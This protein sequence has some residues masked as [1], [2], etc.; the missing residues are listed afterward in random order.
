MDHFLLLKKY[1]IKYL[2]KYDST[3]KNL[4]RVLRN[5]IRRINNASKDKKF[6]LFKLIFK[7]I[8]ELE[9]KQILNDERYTDKKI[10][11]FSSQ[12]KSKRFI[13]NYLMQKGIEKNLM[14]NLLKD[15]ELNNPDWELNSA[16]IFVRKKILSSNNE[17]NTEKKLAKMARAGFDYNISKKMLGLD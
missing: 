6:I 7:I 15:F 2:S 12:G 10:I 11:Y 14:D 9:S 5:K 4:E 3:K 1:A 13:K 17:K 16:K 8:E